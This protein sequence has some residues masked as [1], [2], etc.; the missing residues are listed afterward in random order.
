MNRNTPKKMKRTTSASPSASD[1]DGLESAIFYS[2]AYRV[3]FLE[4][5]EMEASKGLW[6]SKLNLPTL[7]E[8]VLRHCWEDL[9]WRH[10]GSRVYSKNPSNPYS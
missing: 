7:R 1:L 9:N 5:I 10:D 3:K 8:T 2:V 6:L 4:L